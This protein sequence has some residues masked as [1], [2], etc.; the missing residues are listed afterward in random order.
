MLRFVHDHPMLCA[1]VVFLTVGAGAAIISDL[2]F[3]IACVVI[4]LVLRAL[5]AQAALRRAYKQARQIASDE[6]M[7]VYVE[8]LRRCRAQRDRA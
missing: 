5:W 8:E 2:I 6:T 4:V 7:T 3:R 1:N